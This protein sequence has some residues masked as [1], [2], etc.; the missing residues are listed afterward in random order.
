[1]RNPKNI[2]VGDK[3]LE[4]I[5]KEHEQRMKELAH[6]SVFDF[7]ITDLSGADLSDADLVGV[8]LSFVDLTGA[9]LSGA[10]LFKANLSWSLLLKANLSNAILSRANLQN[11]CLRHSSLCKASLH[12]ADLRLADLTGADLHEAKLF[13]TNITDSNLHWAKNVPPI[14]FAC[15]DTGSFIGWKKAYVW[16][17]PY[18]I[19]AVVQ[20]EIPEDAKRLSATTQKCRCDKA[21]VLRITNIQGDIEFKEAYSGFDHNFIYRVGET[22]SVDNFDEDRWNECSTGIHFFTDRISAVKYY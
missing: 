21:K 8:D 1:M 4:Q 7:H 19:E 20:L 11:T 3:T 13:N 9:N 6:G 14:P 15:P 16:M 22:V 18:I 5:L 17:E 10:G 2:I 12:C